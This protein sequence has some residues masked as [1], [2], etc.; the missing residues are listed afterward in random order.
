MAMLRMH[1]PRGLVN[2]ITS[3]DGYGRVYVRTPG[4]YEKHTKGAETLLSQEDGFIT[5]K[6]VGQGDIPSPLL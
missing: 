4:N 5:G 1:V 6:G 2:Y 3:Q